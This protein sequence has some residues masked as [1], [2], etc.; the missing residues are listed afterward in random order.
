MKEE[1][2]QKSV[3]DYCQCGGETKVYRVRRFMSQFGPG[4]KTYH[5]CVGDCRSR[6]VDVEIDAVRNAKSVNVMDFPKGEVNRPFMAF[7]KTFED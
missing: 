5:R 2:E 3:G 6:F 1:I 7:G 4:T